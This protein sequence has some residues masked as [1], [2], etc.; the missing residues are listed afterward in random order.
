MTYP[1]GLHGKI[2]KSQENAKSSQNSIYNKGKKGI[3]N[4]GKKR[5]FQKQ[6]VS[7]L[8]RYYYTQFVNT[9]LFT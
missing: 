7:K 4:K 5:D 8:I 1:N 6:L 9:F 3:Y 2:Q